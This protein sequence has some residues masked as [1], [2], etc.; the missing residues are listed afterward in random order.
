MR[1]GK[2]L[3]SQ[4]LV[5]EENTWSAF[6]LE[7]PSFDFVMSC[8]ELVPPQKFWSISSYY[9]Y[10]VC[11]LH[12]QI[13]L[14]GNF[15]LNTGIPWATTTDST[16]CFICKEGEE[17]LHHFLFDRT[18]FREHFDQLLSSLSTKVIRSNPTDGNHMFDFLVN[19]KQHQKAL[20]VTG[21]LPLPFDSATIIMITHFVASAVGKIYK[22]RTEKF[23]EMEAP[24]IAR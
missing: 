19:F 16:I 4:K 7:H 9:I 18:G 13:S 21:C 6:V 24:W 8:L 12:V 5:F 14:M 1:N 2:R 3:Q 10:L 22:F 20:L 11:R 23:R 15:G 17:T